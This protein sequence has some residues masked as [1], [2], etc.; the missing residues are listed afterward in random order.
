MAPLGAGR[1]LDLMELSE[2]HHH[3]E[4][5][6]EH[7]EK[8]KSEK[9]AEHHSHH[10]HK[11]GSK[12]MKDKKSTTDTKEHDQKD[13]M[14]IP[15]PPFMPAM[16]PTH[17]DMPGYGAY[18]TASSP[19]G[20]WDAMEEIGY[21]PFFEPMG[22]FGGDA[23]DPFFGYDFPTYHEPAPAPF[24]GF[25]GDL[26][27][28]YG[29]DVGFP[30][31]DMMTPPAPEFGLDFVEPSLG[32]G[33]EIFLGAPTVPEPIE[34]GWGSQINLAEPVAAFNAFPGFE[35]A[36]LSNRLW[37]SEFQGLAENALAWDTMGYNVAVDPLY[38]QADVYGYGAWSSPIAE[39][40]LD[41][42]NVTWRTD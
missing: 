21:E 17:S 11:H 37:D 40:F 34:M 27:M 4:K 2:H 1:R 5:H 6:A 16:L 13:K 28:P 22:A 31:F 42:P 3:H 26:A 36:E 29:P 20:P 30:A 7:E 32:W 38:P 8:A 23:Y 19:Y 15:E 12:K 25:R 14:S 9:N 33:K 18:Y 41:V 24:N 10:H 39:P 35:A